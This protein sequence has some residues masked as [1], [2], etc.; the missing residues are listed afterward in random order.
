MIEWLVAQGHGRARTTYR[1]RDWLFSRQRYWGEPF[2]VLHLEDGRAVRVPDE[3]LPVELPPMQDFAPSD[4]GRPPLAK[5]T[6]WVRTVDP[7]SGRP[8]QRDTDTMPGWAGSCWYYL[9]FMDPGNASAP[10]APEAARYWQ[11]VD[12]YI[13]GTEHAVLHLLYARFWHK[14]LYDLGLVTTKEPFARLFNQGMLG[15]FAYKDP[16]G[17]L[18]LA[19]EVRFEN[20]QP[21]HAPTGAQLEQVLAKM[22]KSLKNV[23]NPDDV[24]REFGVDTFRLYEMFMGPLADSKPWNPRDVP[25]C[26]RFLER[27]WRLFVDP[28]GQ[29]PLR[30]HLA[31]AAEGAPAGAALELERALNRAI[32]R[33]DDS[34]QGFNFNT[35][36]A[37]RPSV[38]CWRWPPSR[39]ISPR[40]S[41]RASGTAPAWPARLGPRCSPSTSRTT[42][43]N[44][45]CRC[46]ASCAARCR[47]P[48]R[49]TRPLRSP[50]R[51]APCPIGWRARTSS[52][53]STCPAG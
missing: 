49:S 5:A 53:R 19:D 31:Q 34:F 33:V 29:A 47:S 37:T 6:E 26:R 41:G 10:F 38:S 11:Q 22:S 24:C 46:S 3:H 36:V 44:W 7:A 8:A 21:V 15:A 45:S 48:R 23:V 35:A 42:R 12:L 14:V 27:A 25:G 50:R 16:S 51:A 20:D 13:G 32:K 4:D 30:P 43:S 28:D 9:R 17:R 2:P 52:R 18:V 40:S 39:P 1:L